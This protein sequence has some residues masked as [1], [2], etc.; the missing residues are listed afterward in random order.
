MRSSIVFLLLVATAVFGVV[1]LG[2][3]EEPPGPEGP[4]DLVVD[5]GHTRWTDT[6]SVRLLADPIEAWQ[7]RLEL[8]EQAQHHIHLTTFSW[9][10]DHYGDLF[11]KRLVEIILE[12]KKTNPDFKVYCLL[13]ATARGMFDFSFGRLEKAGAVVRSFNPNLWGIGP[14]Y[15]VRMHDKMLIVD[16][17]RAIVGGRNI[18][19]EYYEVK[20]W[21]LDFGVLLE[22]DA[23]W[24]LQ[25]V[26]LKSWAMSSY[27]PKLFRFPMPPDMLRNRSRSLLTTGR[28]P[29]GKSP[30]T[31]FLTSEYFPPV[32]DPPG[33]T[34]VAVL[35][36]NPVVQHTA[37]TTQLLTELVRGA[38]RQIDVM[39]PFPNFPADLTEAIISAAD[40]GVEVRLFVNGEEAALRRGPFM[41]AGL[42]TV[43]ELLETDIEIWAWQGNGELLRLLEE[44]GCTPEIYPP[45]ALHGKLVR[46]DDDVT[47]VHSSNFNIRSTYYNTEAGVV[48][49]DVSFNVEVKELL[50]GLIS[51]R[52]LKLE[53]GDG[54]DPVA[55]ERVVGRLGPEDVPR[56][57][58]ILGKKQPFVD[59]WGVLW[60]AA[61]S[62]TCESGSPLRRLC[63]A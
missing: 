37:A 21:W 30:L 55:V 24:D 23:V 9:H 58:E 7:A 15:D 40:R 2:A 12:R 59:S 34:R 26:F 38:S 36:D 60:C 28:L 1:G 29:S 53:C 10:K 11:R 48:V 63:S 33:N 4:G 43:I 20:N 31:P 57:R 52:D 8:V 6:N 41:W 47:I 51:L 18:S 16:G 50:D 3:G 17:K 22:G 35:Y 46:I 56:L 13:D 42:P 49:R 5:I 61:D 19:N 39:T 25:M 62:G 44:T 54:L 45:V 32:A 14:M 27:L